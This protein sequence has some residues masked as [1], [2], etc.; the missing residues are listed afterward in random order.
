M[1]RNGLERKRPACN[2]RESAKKR[3]DRLQLEFKA[4]VFSH[5][6]DAHGKR[7]AQRSSRFSY[8]A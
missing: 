6:S 5:R 8:F 3:F 1:L 2:E 7:D 4:S